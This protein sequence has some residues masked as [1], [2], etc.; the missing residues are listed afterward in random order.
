MLAGLNDPSAVSTQA[1]EV[2]NASGVAYSDIGNT[3]AVAPEAPTMTS[4]LNYV[5]PSKSTVSGQLQSLFSTENPYL[6]QA[7][8]SGVQSANSRGLLNTSMSAGASEREAIKAALPIA[9]QDATTYAAAQGRQQEGDITGSIENA[10]YNAQGVL[11]QQKAN[12]LQAQTGLEAG[13]TTARDTALAQQSM[14]RDLQQQEATAGNIRIQ[15]D[16]QK[17]L[18]AA[19]YESA[20]KLQEATIA[21]DRDAIALT[22]QIA[23]ARDAANNLAAKE[24][25]VQQAANRKVLEQM[26]LD[27]EAQNLYTNVLGQLTNTAL[28]SVNSLLNNIDITDVGG[29]MDV[30][31]GFIGSTALGSSAYDTNLNVTGRLTPAG[32]ASVAFNSSAEPTGV[33]PQTARPGQ[34]NDP[35]WESIIS[36]NWNSHVAAY[37]IGW[38]TNRTSDADR[39][40]NMAEMVAEY[41]RQWAAKN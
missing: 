1:Q 12:Q 36:S 5:D 28:G 4:G 39:E 27:A 18:N 30:I 6:T 38:D 25:D 10:G 26:G 34:S 33:A 40:G 37:G 19:G 29:A 24:L 8:L 2:A 32:T 31:K 11:Q 41:N 23:T 17:M 35:L 7:R 21:G 9:S 14:A 20:Q 15:G 3:P 16:V 22:G 13:Y